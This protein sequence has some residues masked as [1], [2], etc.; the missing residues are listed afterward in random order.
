MR[1]YYTIGDSP[2]CNS[3]TTHTVSLYVG[4]TVSWVIVTHRGKTSSV[5]AIAPRGSKAAK[6]ATHVEETSTTLSTP[7]VKFFTERYAARTMAVDEH[8]IAT[9]WE[10]KIS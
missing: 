7:L 3:L 10:A 6:S 8:G 9:S 5:G 1:K 2:T 4:R